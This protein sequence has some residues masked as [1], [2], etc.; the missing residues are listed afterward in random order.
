LFII[1]QPAVLIEVFFGI[2]DA[3]KQKSTLAIFGGLILLARSIDAHVEVFFFDV[4]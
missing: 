4:F 2:I 3:L 1:K